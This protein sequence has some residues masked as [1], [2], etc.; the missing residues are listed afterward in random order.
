MSRSKCDNCPRVK[1]LQTENAKLR[2]A[3][4]DARRAGKR[5]CAPFSKGSPKPHPKRPGR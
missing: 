1:A 2:A 5:P 4:E 3:L